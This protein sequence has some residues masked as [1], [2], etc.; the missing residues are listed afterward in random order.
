MYIC[1]YKSIYKSIYMS[2][3]MSIYIYIYIYSGIFPSTFLQ[4]ITGTKNS[5]FN[6][7]MKLNLF[8]CFF[9][10]V[11][12]TPLKDFPYSSPVLFTLWFR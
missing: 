10:F 9:Y 8:T 4:P 3:Y 6:G 7:V 2:T 1:I 11:F 5:I 12:E